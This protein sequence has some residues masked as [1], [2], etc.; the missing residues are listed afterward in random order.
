M[1]VI[2]ERMHMQATIEGPL[3]MVINAE[4]THLTWQLVVRN[5]LTPVTVRYNGA[6]QYIR[7]GMVVQT[8]QGKP[9]EDIHKDGAA[10]A[11]WV[12]QCKQRPLLLGFA[13]A[14]DGGPLVVARRGVQEGTS[15]NKKPIAGGNVIIA[16]AQQAGFQC[17]QVKKGGKNI[18]LIITS[19]GLQMVVEK[20]KRDTHMYP[21][22]NLV[23]QIFSP[24]SSCLLISQVAR[25]RQ[26]SNIF[27]YI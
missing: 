19:L 21:Y 7:N 23:S 13:V 15:V 11:R 8:V 22:E 24:D 27:L 18:Q 17:F 16:Q 14:E 3:S 5:V 1:S 12:Q 25:R 9:W 26:V 4:F 6:T 20:K 10:A 2:D